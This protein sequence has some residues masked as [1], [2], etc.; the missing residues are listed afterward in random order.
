MICSGLPRM[1]FTTSKNDTISFSLMERRSKNKFFSY[2]CMAPSMSNLE[3][4]KFL[5]QCAT[6]AKERNCQ[7][8]GR[9][10]VCKVCCS[11]SMS[12]YHQIISSYLL[13]LIQIRMS[14]FIMPYLPW[15]KVRV[16]SW[17]S[18]LLKANEPNWNIILWIYEQIICYMS[19]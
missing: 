9:V 10:L 17:C 5:T 14:C 8:L 19:W 18:K 15:F 6:V 3:T 12:V 2:F 7:T 1:G 16:E 13:T 11:R 4:W